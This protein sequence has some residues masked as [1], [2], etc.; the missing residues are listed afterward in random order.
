VSHLRKECSCYGGEGDGDAP[1]LTLRQGA[2]A[3][4]AEYNGGGFAA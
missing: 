4:W 2:K 1:G 3:A